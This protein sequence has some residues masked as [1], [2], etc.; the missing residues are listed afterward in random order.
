MTGTCGNCGRECRGK[1]ISRETE[2]VMCAYWAPAGCLPVVESTRGRELGNQ[3][4]SWEDGTLV[5][6]WSSEEEQE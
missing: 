3:S 2:D 6:N 1:T 4:A 5:K